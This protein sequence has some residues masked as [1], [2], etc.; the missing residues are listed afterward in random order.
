MITAENLNKYLPY[1]QRAD[2]LLENKKEILD[3]AIQNCPKQHS[4]LNNLFTQLSSTKRNFLFNATMSFLD[5][6]ES[7]RVARSKVNPYT[8][9]GFAEGI[10]GIGAGIYTASKT[11]ES[12][13][14][15]DIKSKE[16]AHQAILEEAEAYQYADEFLNVLKKIEEIMSNTPELNYVIHRLEI[17]YNEK[18][19]NEVSTVI[20]ELSRKKLGSKKS[21]ERLNKARQ[22]LVSLG[23]F[24]DS[25]DKLDLCDEL[26]K[27]WKKNLTIY[28]ICGCIF[29]V[30]Y[31]LFCF[32]EMG[33]II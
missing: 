15:A 12:N 3:F 21:Q 19:Y 7:N 18:Q 9:G 24:K 14:Q 20:D 5:Q 11:A 17:Q 8:A 23:N 6:S 25:R 27:K 4:S 10:G 31:L 26:E 30:L 33:E 1:C 28:S 32:L 29:G 16:Y 22:K 13:R 2:F